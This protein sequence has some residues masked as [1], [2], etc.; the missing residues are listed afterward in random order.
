MA[1]APYD[2]AVFGSTPLAALLAGLLAT[3]HGKR[4]CLVGDASSAFRLPRSADLS[5]MPATRPQTWALLKETTPEVTRL[6]GRLKGRSG[7][8]RVD[9]IFVA[10]TAAGADALAHMR[11]MAL[12]H[13]YAVE[14]LAD[15]GAIGGVAYR[16]RDAVLL[17]RAQLD[18]ALAA[19]LDKAGVGQLSRLETAASVHRDG[20]ARLEVHGATIEA[21]HS[22]LADDAAILEHVAAAERDRTLLIQPAT[23]VLTEPTRP[24]PAAAML[25]IDRQVTLMRGRSG[26]IVAM[27]AG[28][29]EEAIARIGG[30]LAG[31]GPL[32]RAGQR[33][34]RTVGTV[35]G[36]PLIG[37]ARGGRAT[38]LA[39]LGIGGAF[40]APALA[41]LVAGAASARET[42][43]FGAHEAGR[44]KARALVAEF[45]GHA[46]AAA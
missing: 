34:F 22:I 12:G 33:I 21:A 24:L 8:Q 10:E 16:L 32:R 44:G 31:R 15:G 36:A 35:D 39:G 5:V 25:Y 29:P 23:A 26:G 7:M 2:F 46:G 30:C 41:R 20:T 27:A 18:P 40:F 13:G 9:P 3:A 45:A 4:V 1:E 6:L 38:V 14:R 37:T 19:W 11:H 43:Y 28:A 42:D 17:H